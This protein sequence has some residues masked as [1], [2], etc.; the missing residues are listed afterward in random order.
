MPRPPKPK[1]QKGAVKRKSDELKEKLPLN[2]PKIGELVGDK[3]SAKRTLDFSESSKSSRVDPKDPR[4]SPKNK[5]QKLKDQRE[6]THNSPKS[7]EKVDGSG[8]NGQNLNDNTEKISTVSNSKNRS[9]LSP[10]SQDNGRKVIENKNESIN[11]QQKQTNDKSPT[12]KKGGSEIQKFVFNKTGD[13]DEEEELDYEDDIGIY[14]E[15]ESTDAEEDEVEKKTVSDRKSRDQ[16]RFSDEQRKRDRKHRRRDRSRSRSKN[17]RKIYYEESS[18]SSEDDDEAYMEKML[19]MMKKLRKEE[20]RSKR[21]SRRRTRSRT[22][23]RSRSRSKHSRRRASSSTSSDDSTVRSKKGTGSAD[24]FKSPSDTLIYAPAIECLGLN[25]KMKA[26]YQTKRGVTDMSSSTQDSNSQGVTTETQNTGERNS[27]SEQLINE[28]LS[29][30]RLGNRDEKSAS[31]VR[32]EVRL[33]NE[34]KSRMEL[35]REKADEAIIQAEKYK[36]ELLPEGMLEKINK[37]LQSNNDDEFFYT[38]CHIDQQTR[39]KIKKGLFVE[40]EKLLVRR[41]GMRPRGE[42]K[43]DIVSKDG[44]T[45]IMSTEDKE[46][47]INSIHKWEQAFRVYATIYT[48]ENPERGSEIWQ[49]IDTIHRAAKTFHWEAV[50]E[51]D[52]CFRQLMAEYPQRSWSQIYT[53]MWNLTL[54]EGGQKAQSATQGTSRRESKT[55]VCWRFNKNKCS[56]G[57]RCKFDHKCSYCW[58]YNHPGTQCPRKERKSSQSRQDSRQGKDRKRSKGHDKDSQHD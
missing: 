50:A 29:H 45:S 40:L 14:V 26:K 3:K 21:R 31:R 48:K 42:H 16:E 46:V 35:A 58:S 55:I 7:P 28:F 22:K 32:S 56:Y 13:G 1:T 17:R 33:P 9:K 11:T 41:K 23:S 18:S 52:Y 47:K 43:V 27:S 54:C 5:V 51:Y 53:Q 44:V 2:S 37:L 20:K 49:Y 25:N 19:K 39:E 12:K 10:K 57:P 4:Q 15:A 34:Q 8:K 6:K 24:K 38:N 30:M 36:A